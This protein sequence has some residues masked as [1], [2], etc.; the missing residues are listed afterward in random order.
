MS[1]LIEKLNTTMDNDEKNCLIKAW[2]LLKDTS[3]DLYAEDLEDTDEYFHATESCK[4][5]GRFL[6]V[7]VIEHEEVETATAIECSIAEC[8]NLKQEEKVLKLLAICWNEFVKL[9]TQH[10]DERRDFCNGIHR[11]R[12]ILGMRFARDSRP[13][14]FP[15]KKTIAPEGQQK[16]ELWKIETE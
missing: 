3:D 12:D 15:I 10:P 11:C 13:D 5:L 9:D 1:N 6:D 14:L 4:A 2:N 8:G 16:G 7:S